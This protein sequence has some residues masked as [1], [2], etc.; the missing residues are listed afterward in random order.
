MK[1]HH[2]NTY[3]DGSKRVETEKFGFDL[4]PAVSSVGAVVIEAQNVGTLT[5]NVSKA[6]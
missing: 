5:I 1:T 4:K 3:E 6:H 2:S